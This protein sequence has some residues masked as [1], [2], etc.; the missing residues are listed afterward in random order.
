MCLDKYTNIHIIIFTGLS[1][2]AVIGVAA[3]ITLTLIAIVMVTVIIL[4]IMQ[5]DY[6]TRNMPSG[7]QFIIFCNFIFTMIWK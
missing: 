6:R 5:R 1:T 2:G 3:G 7:K 4:G